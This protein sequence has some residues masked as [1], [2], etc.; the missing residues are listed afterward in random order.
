MI[1]DRL[2]QVGIQVP[3][4]DQIWKSAHSLWRQLNYFPDVPP[5]CILMSYIY[6]LIAANDKEHVLTLE[7]EKSG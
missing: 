3:L 6:E 5:T 2:V 7:L 1:M 4:Q